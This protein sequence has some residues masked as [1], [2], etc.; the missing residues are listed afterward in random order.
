MI[1]PTTKEVARFIDKVQ[2]T[3]HC[4]LWTDYPTSGG[5]GHFWSNGKRIKA[6]HFSYELFVG[7]I[8]P[9]KHILHRREC[10]NRNCVNPHHLYT[11]TN[12]DNIRDRM[13]WGDLSNFRLSV[14]DV[15]N[16][17]RM[18]RENTTY[19]KIASIYDISISHVSR[20]VKGLRWKHLAL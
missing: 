14:K 18:R 4:W 20:I 13:I 19:E 9:G 2:I 1:R 11:G 3:K 10:G 8:E 7:P 12:S 16:I 17:R 5:Y 15:L 6:S